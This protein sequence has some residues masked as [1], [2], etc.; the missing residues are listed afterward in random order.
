MTQIKQTKSTHFRKIAAKTK[1]EKTQ[2]GKELG[3]AIENKAE[4][5][6]SIGEWKSSIFTVKEKCI[7]CEMC[8]KHCP[9]AAITTKEIGD[10]KRAEIDQSFCKGCGI[11]EN[12]CP[13]EAIEVKKM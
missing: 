13:V 9:E 10:K 6:P 11:C 1:Q 3:A 2:M 4:K 12:V 7:G 8:V 5:Y